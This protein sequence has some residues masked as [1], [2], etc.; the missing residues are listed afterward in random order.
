MC[1]IA[2]IVAFTNRD[3]HYYDQCSRMVQVQRHRGPDDFGIVTVSE[4]PQ[5]VFGHTRLS[6]I[7]LSLG[8]HQPMHDQ[9]T[10]NYLVFNGEIYN[11][12]ELRSE[13]KQQGH[14]FE[15]DSD[16]EVILKAYA[17]WR[18][19]FC[20]HLHGMFA[21]ALWDSSK[22]R[23]LLTRDRLGIKPLYYYKTNGLLIFAS[24]VRAL[25]ESDLIKRKL[26]IK[27]LLSYLSYGSVQEPYTLVE[28]IKSL[29]PAHFMTV[30]D[31]KV[32]C[33]SY[34]DL[35]FQIKERS[36]ME[37]NELVKEKLQQAVKSRLIA[38]VP[39]GAFLSGGIDSTAIVALMQRASSRRIKTFSIV[40]DDEKTDERRY[41]RLAS[42]RL[43]CE[44]TELELSG[45]IVKTNL[46]K[47]MDAF[48]Q[49][50]V[51]GL[52]T[53]FVSKLTKDAG[54]TVALSGVGGDEVFAGYEGFSKPLLIERH[55]STL[56]KFP[57]FS[58][59]LMSRFGNSEKFRKIGEMI[60]YSEHPYFLSR[61]VFSN[62]QAEKLLVSEL[63]PDNLDWFPVEARQLA[64]KS[65]SLSPINRTSLLE[66]NTYMR[67]TLLRDTDQMS[68]AHSLEI[69]V[70]LID[71]EL[72]E[73]MM[74]IPGEMKLDTVTAKP[75]LVAG[76]NGDIPSECIYRSKQGFVL[77]FEK[78]FSEELR[79]DMKHFFLK[80]GQGLYQE[81]ALKKMWCHY[82]RGK[83][84]WCRVWALYVLNYWITKYGISL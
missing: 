9:Q 17:Q 70:P 42:Q 20:K 3:K 47:A 68:M 64:Q 74:S 12:R 13:L 84:N 21:F 50:S 45:S 62:L 52:N 28:G 54:L 40:F 7:D 48:D 19:D 8:G 10:G 46:T 39:L 30:E 37:V 22:K 57:R 41:S 14:C 27:G 4:Y 18:D 65:L 34:W 72:V 49:P 29:S 53:W 77:P 78:W 59:T 23:L 83:V 36:V 6:I 44:H 11:Y 66:M 38:D 24:E 69:R 76:A 16:T 15:T 26:D 43:G 33:Q 58:G 1:G 73:L 61:Q 67:S 79:E 82:E 56:K 32:K 35:S 81:N 51:D 5:C 60:N 63:L 2:G 25:I 55:A 71:H 80:P 75:L 31:E